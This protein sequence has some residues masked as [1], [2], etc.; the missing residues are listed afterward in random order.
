MDFNLPEEL[1]MLQ[2][3]VRDFVKE[4]LLPEE[5]ELLG[6]EGEP[7]T[8]KLYLSPETEAVLMKTVKE[9]GLWGI[10][11]PE[12]LGGVGLDTLGIC[13]VE[14]ELAKTI[15][16]FNFGDVT[17]L[18]FDCNDAQR[19]R[20][21]FLVLERKRHAAVALLEPGKEVDPT[22]IETRAEKVTGGY[23]L[24]GSKISLSQI[25]ANDFALVFAITSPNT[26]IREG[27][28]CLLVDY[29]TPGFSVANGDKKDWPI[30]LQKP[31]ALLFSDCLVPSENVL[32]EEGRA[33]YLGDK[34]L[35]Q[36]RITRGARCV[37]AATRLL[38][39]ST[40][41]AKTWEKFDQ[42]VSS[43]LSVQAALADMATDIQAARLMV[44]NA[45]W[46]A[47]EGDKIYQEAAMVKVFTTQMLT[48]T[49]DGAVHVHGGPIYAQELPSER[50]CQSA[51]V[52]S[53]GERALELQRAIII[54]DLLKRI[55]P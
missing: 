54:S 4:K 28:T 23:L 7:Q 47:D 31:A 8:G 45:A 15:V 48:R 25:G 38:E 34:W 5:R 13:L 39:V 26:Q 55:G 37:G 18:L 1:K 9:M 6:R 3:L 42:P 24:N 33:F 36:R 14:E 11:L 10:N 40:E 12:E 30:R 43:S 27:A 35:P 53:T 52:T 20:Y 17:P 22:A 41:Y 46:K 49:A 16:P 32:G 29:G 2:T 21:L 19:E 44:Y 51:L 50:L